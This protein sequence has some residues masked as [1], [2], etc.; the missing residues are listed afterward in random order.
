MSRPTLVARNDRPRRGRGSRSGLV[1]ADA[2]AGLAVLAVLATTIVIA[3][4]SQR[5][6]SERLSDSRG[7]TWAAER[8]LVAMQSGRPAAGEDVRVDSVPAESAPEG[9]AWVRVHAERRGRSAELIGL[10][11]TSSVPAQGGAR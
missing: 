4:R 1:V 11:P 2:V 6:A 8:A 9:F 10:V 3:V 7:A 5:M